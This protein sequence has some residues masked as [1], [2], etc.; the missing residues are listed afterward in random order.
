MRGP[1]VWDQLAALLPLRDSWALIRA[2]GEEALDMSF[3]SRT[4]K[5]LKSIQT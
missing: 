3:S 5:Y 1:W 2:C 4:V